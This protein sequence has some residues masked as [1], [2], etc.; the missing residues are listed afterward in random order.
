MDTAA[1][2]TEGM[3]VRR[4][5]RRAGR[6]FV[7]LAVA[8]C[9]SLPV[10]LLAAVWLDLRSTWGSVDAAAESFV[11][12]GFTEV[13]TVSQGPRFCF[14]MC[15]A[16]AIVVTRL[17]TTSLPPSE[18]CARLL[19]Q[20]DRLTTDLQRA[21][22]GRCSWNGTMGD[23]VSVGGVVASRTRDFERFGPAGVFGYR[24]TD[25][26]DV[27]DAPLVAWVEFIAPL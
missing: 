15:S 27:P 3:N 12:E 14:V 23:P 22:R 11:P 21:E 2:A 18:A 5:G 4:P 10:V 1:S 16:D 17:L 6:W 19:A 26:T 9:A 24:W 7:V 8:L 20:M 25:V 13:E